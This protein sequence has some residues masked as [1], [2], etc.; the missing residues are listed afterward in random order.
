MSITTYGE[1][2]TAIANWSE[3]SDLTAVIPDFVT[4]AQQEIGRVLRCK[5][6]T[7]TTTL[8][9]AGETLA[10]PSDFEALRY[11]YFTA[12]RRRAVTVVSPESRLDKTTQYTS[13][14]YPDVVSVEG[15]YFAFGP[16]PT[17]TP[18]VGVLYYYTPT[19]MS[20]TSDTNPVLAKYP[21][22][23]LYGALAELYRYIMDDNQ[24]D[25]FETR[26]Q[27]MMAAINQSEAK[28]AMS[29]PLQGQVYPG[30]VV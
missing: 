14:E 23:Y 6:N 16:V 3:R 28:D 20:A 10:V 30:G 1:L 13:A 26:F 7:K 4:Y 2:K 29:G 24:A 17:Q 25:R 19:A 18:S 21:M 8:T 15:G 5:T 12:S 22:L 9:L 11:M 27:G